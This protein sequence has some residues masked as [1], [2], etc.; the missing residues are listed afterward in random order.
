MQ[1][2][3]L[4][5]RYR[6]GKLDDK[7]IKMKAIENINVINFRDE[8][9]DNSIDILMDAYQDLPEYGEQSRKRAKR[10][11]KW[12]KKHSTLFVIAK[13]RNDFAGFI[14]AD[15]SWTDMEGKNVGEIHELSVRKRFWGKGVGDFLLNLALKHFSQKGLKQ[16]GLWVGEKNKRAI[17]FYEKHRF[18][19]TDTKY[20]DWLRMVRSL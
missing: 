12:L 2:P 6:G 8:L 19:K 17:K 5:F 20:Y 10:Y 15:A 9:L 4:K 18:K 16:A 14:V 11:I 3:C 7:L 13:V 1:I